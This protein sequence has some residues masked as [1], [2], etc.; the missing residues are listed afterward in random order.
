MPWTAADI[1]D[2]SGKTAVVTGGNGGLGLETVRELARHGAHV[3]IGAR[4]LDKAAAAEAEV[5]AGNPNAS[6]EVRKLDLSSLASVKAFAASVLEDHPAIDLLFNNAGVMGTPEWETEDGFEMQFGTN[7][8]GHFALTAQLMPALL[9]ADRARIVNTTSTARFSAGSYDLSNPHN[10]GSYDPWVAYGYSKRA[11]VHF[12][13]ELERRC[14]EA[15]AGVTV[16]AADPGFSN[17]DLQA[18]SSRNSE[19]SLLSRVFH[20]G[21]NLVGQ[22]AA[23]GALPQLRAGTDPAAEGGTL[24]RPRWI[25]VGAPVRGDIGARL[26]K[27]A[28]LTSLWQV[29]ENE[30]GVGFD[31]DRLV[32]EAGSGAATGVGPSAQSPA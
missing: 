2:Q 3:I 24:Y 17:T 15:G 28:D 6:L 13:L 5:R 29:S 1:P 23:R 20:V 8:L 19:G 4:N 9:R 32:A 27:P 12:T 26:R 25:G 22:S 14:R 30:T 11:N 18:A 31:V 21:V 7:H 16:F 10:R